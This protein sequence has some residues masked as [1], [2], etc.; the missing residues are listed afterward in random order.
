VCA[1]HRVLVDVIR[2]RLGPAG[3]VGRKREGIKVLGRG[4]DR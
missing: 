3:V 2:V 1:E 4:D